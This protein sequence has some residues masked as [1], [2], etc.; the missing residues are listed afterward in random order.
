MRDG[1]CFV[2]I[3]LMVAVVERDVEVDAKLEVFP[4][5]VFKSGVLLLIGGTPLPGNWGGRLNSPKEIFLPFVVK[6]Q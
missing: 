1:L 5:I 6:F 2:S 4:F 3:V